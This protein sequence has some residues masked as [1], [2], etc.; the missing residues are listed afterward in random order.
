[1]K[2]EIRERTVNGRHM[3]RAVEWYE[4]KKCKHGG[5]KGRNSGIGNHSD[6]NGLD[7]IKGSRECGKKHGVSAAAVVCLPSLLRSRYACPRKESS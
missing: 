6:V 2:R 4:R 7:G 1:M 3:M 5:K